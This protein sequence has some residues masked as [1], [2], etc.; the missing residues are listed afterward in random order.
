MP[1]PF[2]VFTAIKV[3]TDLLAGFS[4]KKASRAAAVKHKQLLSLMLKSSSAI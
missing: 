3:G 2:A 4:A 1:N